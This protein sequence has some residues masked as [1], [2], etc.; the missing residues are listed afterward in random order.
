MDYSLSSLISSKIR[1][2]ILMRLFLNPEGSAYLRELAGEFNASPSQIKVELDQ[3]RQAIADGSATQV[4]SVS[5]DEPPDYEALI[6]LA[7]GAA[8][9]LAPAMPTRRQ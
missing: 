9:K 4:R 1:I 2:K 5:D 8:P 7:I 3:L 6:K